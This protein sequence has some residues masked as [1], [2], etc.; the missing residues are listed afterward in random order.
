MAIIPIN[1][2]GENE[3]RGKRKFLSD[4][5]D[6]L[7][8]V[9]LAFLLALFAYLPYFLSLD[10]FLLPAKLVILFL[11]AIIILLRVIVK[12]EEHERGVIF[13]FGRFKEVTGPGWK[14]I[15]PVFEDYVRV[16][17]RLKVYTTEPHDVVTKD[18][19]RFMIGAAI[20]MYVSNPKDA[21]V[22]IGDYRSAIIH[23]VDGSLRSIC[24]SSTSDYIV[25]HMDDISKTIKDGINK[26]AGGMKGWGIIVPRIEIKYIQFPQDV[27][28]AMHKKAIK[29][30]ESKLATVEQSSPPADARKPED[31]NTGT[32][33]EDYE[34][35]IKEIK[36]R[37]GLDEFW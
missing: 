31:S 27:Q 14:I 6:I 16:D 26:L 32:E 10:E 5:E 33:A 29:D 35:R 37:I 30:I 34:K 18:K 19:I 1:K 2:D 8:I 23:Y 36:K 11:I 13:R 20:F 4:L 28:D 9:A 17:T 7:S 25:S 12:F 22:N 21:V 3:G 24:G 15:L